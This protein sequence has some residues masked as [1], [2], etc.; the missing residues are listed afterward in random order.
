MIDTEDPPR[1][2]DIRATF[3]MQPRDV[4]L[5]WQATAAARLRL[6]IVML[7]LLIL[8]QPRLALPTKEIGGRLLG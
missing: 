6:E 7:R 5:R 1:P 4:Y 2:L 3:A 8:G